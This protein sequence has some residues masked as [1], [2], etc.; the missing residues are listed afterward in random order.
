M[1]EGFKELLLKRNVVEEVKDIFGLEFE[2]LKDFFVDVFFSFEKNRASVFFTRRCMLLAKFFLEYLLYE[3]KDEKNPKL[4]EISID[5]NAIFP[6]IKKNDCY[7][8]LLTDKSDFYDI[9]KKVE[10]I[11]LVDDICIHGKT[12]EKMAEQLD[13]YFSEMK[14]SPTIVTYVYMISEETIVQEPDKCYKTIN[15]AGWT[16]LSQKIVNVI[17]I[18]NIPYVSY[19]HTWTRKEEP[20]IIDDK[21]KTLKNNKKLEVISYGLDQYDNKECYYIFEKAFDERSSE[22][23]IRCFR[24]Y[25]S[26]LTGT[27]TFV[28]FIILTEPILAQ[29]DD[30]IQDLVKKNKLFLGKRNHLIENFLTEKKDHFI[31]NIK[32]Y[33][34]N[35]RSCFISYMY[36]LY[37]I[38]KY[39]NIEE[40]DLKENYAQD[41][42]GCLEW[43]YGKKIFDLL[44]HQRLEEN[45]EKY[46]SAS[47]PIMNADV[48]LNSID[49]DE[50][51]NSVEEICRKNWQSIESACLVEF[52]LYDKKR[53]GSLDL[54]YV[55]SNLTSDMK[56]RPNE[57][58]Y[59]YKQWICYNLIR[60]CDM[61]RMN[62]ASYDNK[63]GSMLK[64]GELGY[65]LTKKQLQE[66][67]LISSKKNDA[68]NEMIK[69]PYYRRLFF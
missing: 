44:K 65:V 47:K 20:Q 30:K 19:I 31:I 35:L 29:D 51:Q 50:V 57:E 49:R 13:S 39:L 15:R 58:V 59:F 25:Y 14:W 45:E 28:P 24:F 26:K 38:K 18:L 10:E 60:L 2:D 41:I 8:Y 52:A 63:G 62:I 66:D 6:T 16:D 43:T 68:V 5:E 53:R 27:V 34:Y 69:R 22:K 36:G 56:D 11:Y 9:Y 46:F 55:I 4:N 48:I 32:D 21:L 12:L 33:L 23:E 42:S 17:N 40:K 61:G 54:Q 1:K 64:A 67:G 37:F 3:M 7:N